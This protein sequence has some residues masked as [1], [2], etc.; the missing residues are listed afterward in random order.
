VHFSKQAPATGTFRRHSCNALPRRCGSIRA[1]ASACGRGHAG[2]GVQ[3]IDYET[4][5]DAFLWAFA[6]GLGPEFNS[7]L[8]KAWSAAL[9]T[10]STEMIRASQG[11]AGS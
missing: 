10:L 8:R 7:E 11:G 4:A 1:I 3:P 2:Y 6:E 9:I 5:C